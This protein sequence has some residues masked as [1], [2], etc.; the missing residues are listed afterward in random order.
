M[1]VSHSVTLTGLTSDA[2]YHYQLSATDINGNSSV[3]SDLTFTTLSIG[4][5]PE[6]L[7]Y[8]LNGVVTTASHGFPKHFPL[9]NGDWTSPINYAE[10][11]LYMRAEIR[12]QPVSQQMRMHYC[13]WQFGFTL[14]NCTDIRSVEGTSGNVVTWQHDVKTMNKKQGNSIDWVN[15]RQTNG[16]AIKNSMNVPISD[17]KAWNWGGLDPAEVYPLDMRFTV[18]VVPKGQIFSGWENYID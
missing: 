8:D 17:H 5:G 13:V 16:I 15:P 10:G 6:L 12:S 11:T 7:V 4:S 2:T 18:V 9:A 1:V 14:E 3:S